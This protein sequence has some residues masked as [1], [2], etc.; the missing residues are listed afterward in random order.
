MSLGSLGI[1]FP[2]R[3]FSIW[4]DSGITLTRWYL[5]S[6]SVSTSSSKVNNWRWGDSF[7]II[8]RNIGY[9]NFNKYQ[10][11]QFYCFVWSSPSW[12]V[13]FVWWRTGHVGA[14]AVTSRL[15]TLSLGRPPHTGTDM[16]NI[17][18]YQ[19]CFATSI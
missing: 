3:W 15:R 18:E 12:F 11:L 2:L 4:L 17:Q 19:D 8:F 9:L 13:V 10:I 7:K 14:A 5:I 6:E 16:E 1:Y